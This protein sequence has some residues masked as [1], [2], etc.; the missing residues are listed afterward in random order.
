MRGATG[1]QERSGSDVSPIGGR[2][3]PRAAVPGVPGRSAAGGWA[4]GRRFLRSDA[5]RPGLDLSVA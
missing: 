4:S 5:L 2:E 3:L 1:P